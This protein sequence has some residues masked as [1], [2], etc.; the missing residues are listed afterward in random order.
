MPNKASAIAPTNI[1][2]V[3]YMGKDRRGTSLPNDQGKNFPENGSISMCL[4]GLHS[5]TTVE[6]GDFENDSFLL[7]GEN[8]S[9]EADRAFAFIDHIRRQAGI[10][11]RARIQST[12]NFGK[13]RGLSSSASGFAALGMAGAAAAGLQLSTEE[14][15]ALARKG[16]G[17]ASRSIPDGF[18]DWSPAV[19]SDDGSLVKD[20][21]ASSLYPPEY[22]DLADVV[23]VTSTPSKEISSTQA[24]GKVQDSPYHVQRLNRMPK[25]LDHCREILSTRDFTALGEL[26]EEETWDLHLLFISSGIRY[27]RSE[28]LRIMEAVE[29]GRKNVEAYYTLN[30]G[31]DV[32]VICKKSNAEIVAEN[33]KSIEGVE[34]VII[35]TVGK[36]ARI[37]EDHLF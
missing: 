10:S 28:T 35:N 3:K 22:W 29:Q 33:M 30:T 19:F 11:P 21:A 25:K 6:F 18:V 34:E 16:A 12:N 24:H 9:A 17:S 15:S 7:D 32:H 4:D 13:S 8:V 20:S 23:V 26:L 27:L 37:T 2:F 14:L 1:A 31:Q 5:H 36:G